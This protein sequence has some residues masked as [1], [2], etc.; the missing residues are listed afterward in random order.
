MTMAEVAEYLR[1]ELEHRPDVT[2]ILL[3]WPN[4]GDGGLLPVRLMA[5]QLGITLWVNSGPVAP[6]P[7]PPGTGTAAGRLVLTSFN[8]PR[9]P[10]GDWFPI[11]PDDLIDPDPDPDDVPEW[12]EAQWATRTIVSTDHEQTGRGAFAQDDSQLNVRYNHYRH[13]GAFTGLHHY[14]PVTREVTGRLGPM[15]DVDYLLFN[16]GLLG[17]AAVPLT[18]GSIIIVS[19]EEYAGALSRRPSVRRLS[20]RSRALIDEGKRPLAM[21]FGQCWGD[22]A[23]DRPVG[24]GKYRPFAPEPFVLDELATVPP[25]QHAANKTSMIMK[26]HGDRP[27]LTIVRGGV[28]VL[29][30]ETDAQGRQGRQRDR[31]PEPESD[32]LADRARTTGLHTGTGKVSPFD[33]DAARRLNRALRTV[34]GDDVDTRAEHPTLLAEIGAL[35]LLR[36]ADTRLSRAAPHFTMELLKRVVHADHRKGTRTAPSALTEA[37]F[38]HTLG[39]ALTVVKQAAADAATAKAAGLAPPP[40]PK[41]SDFVELPL[42]L[43]VARELGSPSNRHVLSVLS[44]APSAPV[45]TSAQRSD[46]FWTQVRTEEVYER[47]PDRDAFEARILHLA[48]PDPK[49][50]PIARWAVAKALAFGIDPYDVDAL[51]AA[52]VAFQGLLGTNSLITGDGTA[53]GRNLAG[54][55]LARRVSLDKWLVPSAPGATDATAVDTPWGPE[56]LLATAEAL[57]NG[58]LRVRQ[59]GGPWYEVS[60]EEYVHLLIRDPEILRHDLDV[61][62]VLGISEVGTLNPALPG[63]VLAGLGRPVV[64]TDGPFDLTVDTS[65]GSDGSDDSDDSDDLSLDTSDDLDAPSR[66]N[67]TSPTAGVWQ[68]LHPGTGPNP[69]TTVITHDPAGAGAVQA[70]A[71]AAGLHPAPPLPGSDPVRLRRVG[72]QVPRTP[73]R[74]SGVPSNAGQAEKAATRAAPPRPGPVTIGNPP[75]PSDPNNLSRILTL[76]TPAGGTADTRMSDAGSPDLGWDLE[77]NP[78]SE[79]DAGSDPDAGETTSGPAPRVPAPAPDPLPT[80]LL[81]VWSQDPVL[82]RGPLDPDALTS[83]VLHLPPDAG[84]TDADRAELIALVRDAIAQ[85]SAGSLAALGAH[86]LRTATLPVLSLN[87]GTGTGLNWGSTT[88]D[89]STDQVGTELPDGTV[90]YARAPWTVTP[91]MALGDRGDHRSVQL[92]RPGGGDRWTVPI[93]DVIEYLVAEAKKLPPGAP[94]AVAWPHSGDLGLEALELLAWRTQR[95]VWSYSGLLD[96]TTDPVTGEQ[97]LTGLERPGEPLGDW[98][99]SLPTDHRPPN[100]ADRPEWWELLWRTRVLVDPAYERHGRTAFQP[101]ED[102]VAVSLRHFRNYKN[103]TTKMH[104]NPATWEFVGTPEWAAHAD[105]YF[106]IHGRPHG[107][108]VP[109]SDGRN[110]KVPGKRFIPALLRRRSVQDLM[111]L[112]KAEVARGLPRRRLYYGPCFSDAGSSLPTS[113]THSAAP[114]PFTLDP[115]ED[116]PD[117]QVLANKSGLVV[118]NGGNRTSGTATTETGQDITLAFTDV[119]DGQGWARDR[120]PE[121]EG[122]QL[123]ALARKAKLPKDP[124]PVSEDDQY[125]ALRLVRALREVFGD[126]IDLHLDYPALFALAGPLEL[127]RRA[128]TVLSAAAPHFTMDLLYRVAEVRK[129]ASGAAPGPLTAQDVETALSDASHAWHTRGSKLSDFVVLKEVMAVAGR[130]DPAGPADDDVRTVLGLDASTRVTSVHRSKYFWAQVQV[131]DVYARQPDEPAFEARILHRPA[132]AQPDPAE[133]DEARTLVARAIATGH[134]A[135]DL[136]T[137]AAFYFQDRGFLGD[138]SLMPATDQVSGGRNFAGTEFPHGVDATM[139]RT[140][141]ATRTLAPWKRPSGPVPMVVTGEALGNGLVRLRDPGDPGGPWYTVSEEELVRLLARDPEVFSQELVVPLLLAISGVGRLNPDLPG[142]LLNGLGRPVDYTEGDVTWTRPDDDADTRPAVIDLTAPGAGPW[143]HV[144]HPNA[145]VPASPSPSPPPGTPTGAPGT[146]PGTPAGTVSAPVTL[147]AATSR[148]AV[149]PYAGGRVLDRAGLMALLAGVVADVRAGVAGGAPAAGLHP[150]PPLPDE[151]LGGSAARGAPPQT[152]IRPSGV[153]SNAGRAEI[154][155]KGRGGV[156]P[157]AGAPPAA[158]PPPPPAPPPARPPPGGPRA[159]RAPPPPR[160]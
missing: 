9:R 138:D 61:P 147:S 26:S 32:R 15:P 148:T 67:T 21:F 137:L 13:L 146:R 110:I 63:K 119:R 43:Q 98:V 82:G 65:D 3:A 149:P 66:I 84:V 53:G 126:D 89:V 58:R 123:D 88:T 50:S 76:A 129:A 62:L 102:G 77:S 104:W 116:I 86:H 59:P 128:D 14:N 55:E 134:D 29:G 7:A 46:Y 6:R 94:I 132:P 28:R 44:T 106:F 97:Y 135:G 108:S 18:D 64:F 112:N 157:A 91:L 90:T 142:K 154:P 57:G 152:P 24:L 45:L 52:L 150:T 69:V 16:H 40:A 95:T 113:W 42:I 11:R 141:A 131:E 118:P 41:L 1:V 54:Q 158:A 17:T 136:D 60:E 33:L 124:G 48:Q 5:H 38:R 111:A 20:R 2:D 39:R 160:P 31:W 8:G 22:A 25:T 85:G 35:E 145:V 71:P 80:V 74:P 36:R 100:P 130:M 70:G 73:E 127:M 120:H 133:S 78:N 143:H 56:A 87:G 81:N 51:A 144:S 30:L 99:R 117:T 156:K 159:P 139:A 68:E 49:L 75:D 125:E 96:V 47:Q 109:L 27:G 4:S 34:F 92:P 122:A 151:T 115:L 19:A 12:W 121:P 155:A 79:S 153:P 107:V 105:Y 72:G 114:P 103:I 101:T 10:V 37:D 140:S 83:R 93:E 23:T